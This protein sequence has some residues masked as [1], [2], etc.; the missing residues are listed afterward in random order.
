MISSYY[1]VSLNHTVVSTSY[2]IPGMIWY[3]TIV[4]LLSYCRNLLLRTF[5]IIPGMVWYHTTIISLYYTVLLF[6]I[7]GVIRHSTAK[8]TRMLSVVQ[9][10]TYV[11]TTQR[12]SQGT[13][14]H[15][16]AYHSATYVWVRIMHSI[17]PGWRGQNAIFKSILPWSA[18]TLM[19]AKVPCFIIRTV[20][21]RCKYTS[22]RSKSRSYR[23]TILQYSSL[24]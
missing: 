20:I 4:S 1:I 14:L 8:N 9:Q 2:I 13:L 3:H 22:R 11:Y 10:C 7:P 5:E 18:L 16:G 21:C 23:S 15:N 12:I 17:I 19:N 6:H 24:H